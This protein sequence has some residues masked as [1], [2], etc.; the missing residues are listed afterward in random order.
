[1]TS[2]QRRMKPRSSHTRLKRTNQPAPP[3]APRPD[4]CSAPPGARVR[5]PDAP[6]PWQMQ[7]P[8]A[9]P[10]HAP[11]NRR[12]RNI[13]PLF[14]A[15]TMPRP[16]QVAEGQQKGAV[17]FHSR[18]RVFLAPRTGLQSPTT[19]CGLRLHL[20]L[21]P[22]PTRRRALALLQPFARARLNPARPALLDDNRHRAETHRLADLVNLRDNPSQHFVV[23]SWNLSQVRVDVNARYVPTNSCSIP[24]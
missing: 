9:T 4:T 17:S 3:P 7:Y 13:E 5:V 18:P 21:R 14:G 12:Q 2:N 22:D 19:S 23:H 15:G 1:M 8:N 6:A 20:H 16:H 24:K 11:C 10:F